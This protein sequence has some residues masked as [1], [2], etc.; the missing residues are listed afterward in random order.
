MLEKKIHENKAEVQQLRDEVK[1][2]TAENG[3]MKEILQGRD[4]ESIEHRKRAEEAMTRGIETYDIVKTNSG[5]IA[6][7][8]DAI[9]RL[10]GSI[11]RH[12]ANEEKLLSKFS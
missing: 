5:R 2:V 7:M 1:S 4:K 6:E 9:N 11:D 8:A 12:I 10:V 3:V